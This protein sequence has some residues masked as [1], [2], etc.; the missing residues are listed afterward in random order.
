M[1]PVSSK[2]LGRVGAL[3]A[4]LLAGTAGAQPYPGPGERPAANPID[5]TVR[6]VLRSGDN[7]GRP[8][9]VV[10][11][12][13]AQVVAFGPNGEL[14]GETPALLGSARGD[15]SAPWIGE[16]ELSDIRPSERTTPAGRFEAG[17]GPN[18]AGRQV[19]WVDYEDAISL[20]PVINTSRSERRPERLAS[21]T[22]ADNR[23]SYGCINV[24]PAFFA[25]VVRPAFARGGVVYILPESRTFAE[26]FPRLT[27]RWRG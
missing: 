27:R 21:P 10:D 24:P 26:V 5:R 23:I 25:G 4:V 22:A 20:H 8:F 17:L 12:R 19:L 14:L 9:I 7:R 16:R 11:K 3:A 15:D 18:A 13:S 6:S 2:R 1:R